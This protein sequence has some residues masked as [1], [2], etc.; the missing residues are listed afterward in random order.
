M[1]KKM[2]Q[3]RMLKKQEKEEAIRKRKVK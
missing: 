2:K 1:K 3:E